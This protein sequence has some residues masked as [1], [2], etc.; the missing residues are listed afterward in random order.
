MFRCSLLPAIAAGPALPRSYG[1]WA[2]RVQTFVLAAAALVLAALPSA[3]AAATDR[4]VR[5]V[6]LGDSLTAGHGLPA[7]GAFPA[8]LEKALR[9][10]GI[11]AEVGNAGVSGDTA[12]GGLARLDWSVPEGTD[13]VIVELGA[14]DM[15]RGI[16]PAVVVSDVR[17]L[18]E[19]TRAATFIQNMAAQ[20]LCAFGA[21]AVLLAAVGLYGVVA[22]G[23]GRRTRE[24]GLRVALG[25]TREGVVR[26]FIREQVGA[27]AAGL[28]AGSLVSAWA[29]GFLQAYLYGLTPYDVRVWLVAIG[30]VGAT[31]MAG[32]LIPAVRACRVDPATALRVE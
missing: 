14:N 3:P 27:V 7:D 2:A 1:V 18:E 29:A 19:H 11:A 8:K 24:I 25:A 21:V 6:V 10:K 31:A 22:H 12:V 23:V 9:A 17:T 20:L 28:V 30:L 4:P 16:D 26:L 32:T 5:I 15:L 13:A